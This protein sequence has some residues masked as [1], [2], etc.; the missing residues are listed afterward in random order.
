M[1]LDM[2]G[3]AQKGGAV[4]SN[5]RISRPD[6]PVAAPRIAAG[7][8]DLLIGADSVVSASKESIVLCDPGRTE[9]VLNTRITPVSDFIRNRDFDFQE[10]AVERSVARS[11]RSTDY[12]LDF[13]NLAARLTGDEIG[14]NLMMLGY[15]WQQ[16]LVPIGREAILQSIELNGVSVKANTDAFNSGRALAHDPARIQKLANAPSRPDLETMPTEDI[17]EHRAA[18]L[19]AYQNEALANRYRNWLAKVD[20]VAAPE[21]LGDNDL[22]RQ[23]AITYARVLA[24]KDEYEVARLYAAPEFRRSLA[25]VFE[26]DI[27]I[28]FNLAP[29]MLPGKAADGRPKK[30]EFGSWILPVF[31]LLA[32]LKV[33][34]GTWADPFGHTADRKLERQLITLYENDLA[35]AVRTLT[36][37]NLPLIRE[38]LTLPWEIRGYGPVKEAAFEKQMA[39]RAEV[40][41]RLEGHDTM[42]IA[43][44]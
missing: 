16:G 36:A 9:A 38:L 39:R 7:S 41:A 5:V 42:A 40:R 1:V 6:R 43:A 32:R 21:R 27:R 14:A 29:P 13:S 17:I 22:K 30:R 24:Y 15:A 19:R 8:A 2:A 23:V 35:L 18:H 4:L 12:F 28:A 20:E 31:R 26:G 10:A 25:K 37:E 34:R 33:L 11:V 44:E 3:L